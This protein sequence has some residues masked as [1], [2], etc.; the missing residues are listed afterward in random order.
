MDGWRM[1][2]E[3]GTGSVRALSQSPSYSHSY[4][5]GLRS[6]STGLVSARRLWPSFMRFCEMC[7]KGRKGGRLSRSGAQGARGVSP[8]VA[9]G[10]RPR[11]AGPPPLQ[12]GMPRIACSPRLA[13]QGGQA[14]PL[15]R[16]AAFAKGKQ[17][18]FRFLFCAEERHSAPGTHT[19]SPPSR[20][21]PRLMRMDP[22]WVC[23]EVRGGE[24]WAR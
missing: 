12:P 19:R 23:E 24:S 5:T 20:T 18:R 10:A 22:S 21:V 16:G 2:M 4:R 7:G 15:W 17:V 9:L 14:R 3:R 13:I 11:V 1:R 8:P 6:L